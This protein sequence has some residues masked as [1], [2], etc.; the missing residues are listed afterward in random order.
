MFN[1]LAYIVL[2]SIDPVALQVGPLA[3]RWY[4]L[5]YVAGFAIAYAVLARLARR[6][7]L[8]VDAAGALTDLVAWGAVGVMVGGRLGWW[9]IY[10][11]GGAAEPW[12][13]PLAVWHGG[14]SFH[15]GLLGV[16]VALLIWAQ[17]YRASV[18]ATADALA[19]IAPFGLFFG[20]LANFI[21][22]ELLGR[23]STVP[24]AVVF[25]GEELPRHP[26]QLYEA[27]LEGPL[28]LLVLWALGRFRL[29]RGQVA[30]GFLITY[31][32]FR[33]AA[34]FTRQP[35][36]QVGFVAFQW[37]TMGQLL[38]VVVA[39]AGAAL[40]LV[41]ACA[42]CVEPTPEAASAV[43]TDGGNGASPAA[44]APVATRQTPIPM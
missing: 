17:H 5:A 15:G 33:F 26:S 23:P 30:A 7:S 27:M 9:F 41:R 31:G 38:S 34:E 18:W 24:W 8:V 6:G 11:R 42:K 43:N 44:D 2:P 10:H 29:K 32:I 21:N 25:P 13:E 37:L 22:A 28:L 20:R 12:Y 40:W 39:V 3:V 16:I 36:E 1:A 4:G 14:M 35:D 19:M